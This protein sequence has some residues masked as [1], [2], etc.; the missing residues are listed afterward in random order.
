MDE[1]VINAVQLGTTRLATATMG[2]TVCFGVD[3]G[4]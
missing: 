1:I 3:P 2:I 4:C